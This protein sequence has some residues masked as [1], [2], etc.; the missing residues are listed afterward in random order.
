MMDRVESI[1]LVS[2]KLFDIWYT[3]RVYCTQLDTIGVSGI[4]MKVCAWSEWFISC[5]FRDG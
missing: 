1:F 2:M 4:A 3:T 5:V